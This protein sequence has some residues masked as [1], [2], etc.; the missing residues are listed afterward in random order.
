MESHY[1]YY[2]GALGDI[3]YIDAINRRANDRYNELYPDKAPPYVYPYFKFVDFKFET[4]NGDRLS[5]IEKLIPD[6][7]FPKNSYPYCYDDSITFVPESECRFG[8]IPCIQYGTQISSMDLDAVMNTGVSNIVM[9]R[10]SYLLKEILRKPENEKYVKTLSKI[11]FSDENHSILDSEPAKTAS[12]VAS[13]ESVLRHFASDTVEKTDEQKETVA[14]VNK[15]IQYLD[16]I[17]VME[18]NPLHTFFHNKVGYITLTFDYGDSERDECMKECLS[19]LWAFYANITE[20]NKQRPFTT[21]ESLVYYLLR[22]ITSEL[23]IDKE[24]E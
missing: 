12:F 10:I 23:D 20:R 18:L 19:E 15:N 5:C 4:V 8:N 11:I 2:R 21:M 1:R 22:Q 16:S 7:D 17:V 6:H 24:L 3:A 9:A 13:I 14:W